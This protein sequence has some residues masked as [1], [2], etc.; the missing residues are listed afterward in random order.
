[1]CHAF[2]I[3][4][5]TNNI[6]VHAELPGMSRMN[7]KVTVTDDILTIRG[8]KSMKRKPKKKITSSSSSAVSA[9]SH[10][11]FTLPD[12]VKEDDVR[13]KFQIMASWR[14]PSQERAGKTERTRM[15]N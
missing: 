10:G 11:E 7:V 13:A 2:D 14:S 4:E 9:N 15:A 8:E 1:M 6:Y 12:N 5:D 3:S